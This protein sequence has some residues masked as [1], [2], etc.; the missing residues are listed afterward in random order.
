MRVPEVFDATAFDVADLTRAKGATTVSV[1]IPARDEAATVGRIVSA[2][3]AR[4]MVGDGLVDEI[5]VI[6]DH[7]TDRTAAVATDAG[8]RVVASA[9][10]LPEFGSGLRK[11]GALWKSVHV[12]T[13]DIIA[14]C[15]ADIRKFDERFIV[16]LIGPMLLNPAIAFVKGFYDRPDDGIGG[17]R[18]TELL[19]R[20]AI[21][22]LLP[23]LASF[24]QP[25]SGE[26]AGRRS[27]LERVPF[28]CGYGVDLGLLIDV[29]RL[30]GIGAIA[31]VDLGT[32]AHRHRPLDELGPQAVEVLTV[33]LRRSGV[34]VAQPA[35]LERPGRAPL[36]VHFAELP[37]LTDLVPESESPT[38]A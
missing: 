32:R 26:Y 15:D 31:Q 23:E 7:S 33:A 28:V 12:A 14:W 2:I 10:T 5:V 19:A 11:G 20:P 6:D 30:V 37:P 25:L 18:V 1:C 21:S 16:G 3:R 9:D 34:P 22:L 4:L 17:G 36:A 27:L 29:V 8:A 38:P 13:G 24:V 35:V